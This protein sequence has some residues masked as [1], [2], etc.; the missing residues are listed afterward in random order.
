MAIWTGLRRSEMKALIWSD[1]SL[2][3]ALAHIKLRAETTKSNRS[4]TL[5]LHHQFAE[6]LRAFRPVDVKP[7]VTVGLKSMMMTAKL[8]LEKAG[9]GQPK[10]RS[11]TI[12]QQ[13]SKNSG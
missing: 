2:D 13:V 7:D 11:V 6:Q 5:A 12:R 4:D 1:I 8:I 9:F 3:G 10:T